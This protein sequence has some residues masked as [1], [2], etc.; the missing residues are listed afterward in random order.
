[1]KNELDGKTDQYETT[2]LSPV[3]SRCRHFHIRDI[4]THTCEAFPDR[5][6]PDIWLG[7]NLHLLPYPGD[8]NI[9]FEQ[10]QP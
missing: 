6:P 4:E 5:I 9:V 8:N 10:V 3:C 7:E 1:M 2:V